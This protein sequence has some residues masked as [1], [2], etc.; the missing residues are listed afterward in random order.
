MT[1]VLVQ[2]VFF[3]H[4]PFINL[5]APTLFLAI[6]LCTLSII[7]YLGDITTQWLPCDTRIKLTFIKV[8]RDLGGGVGVEKLH[9]T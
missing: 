8:I 5:S 7:E 9:V 6:H 4:Q 3:L 2:Y 1:K